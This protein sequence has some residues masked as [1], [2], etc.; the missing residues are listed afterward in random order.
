MGQ[1]D[2]RDDGFL[3]LNL[4]EALLPN[5]NVTLIDRNPP[6]KGFGSTQSMASDGG[7]TLEAIQADIADDAVL[8]VALAGADAL[9]AAG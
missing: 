9:I 4:A 1:P 5:G 7:G 2:K 3:G 8:D 6:A